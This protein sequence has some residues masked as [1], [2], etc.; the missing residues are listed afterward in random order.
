M[1]GIPSTFAIL[2]KSLIA[3]GVCIAVLVSCFFLT[4]RIQDEECP[5]IEDCP[6]SR[7]VREPGEC[8]AKCAPEGNVHTIDAV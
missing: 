1:L 7:R 4:S 6:D 5:G 8:C 3:C 2:F